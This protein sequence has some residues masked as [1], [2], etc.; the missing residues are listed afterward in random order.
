MNV[1]WK[2]TFGVMIV[3]ATVA[4][5]QSAIETGL[6]LSFDKNG[7][8]AIGKIAS[9]DIERQ[10][11]VWEIGTLSLEVTQQL[12]GEPL[13]TRFEIRFGWTDPNSSANAM[14]RA[15]MPPPYGFDRVR[16]VLGMNVLVIF[17][18]RKPTTVPPLAVLN[19]DSGEDTWV[20]LIKQAIG[21]SSLKGSDRV[22]TLL[23]GLDSS[24]E[25]IRVVSMHQ[26]RENAECQNGSGC[27]DNIVNLL[28]GRAKAGTLQERSKA[29]SW[30]D[31]DMYNATAGPTST[32][33]K[34]AAITL[35][36]VADSDPSIR[37]QAIE[38]LDQMIS[39]DRKWR[40][41]LAHLAIP[42]RGA[43]I[44]VLRQA[45]QKGG[46]AERVSSALGVER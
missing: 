6:Y 32:N 33:N 40:P 1:R 11:P 39:P 9:I 38:N 42:N 43:V 30:L 28:S 16:P 31:Y 12:R 22:D 27:A 29:I 14:S 13:P 20:P 3:M 10:S 23:R 19:L 45:R 41:D 18:R 21:F 36:L 46:E 15:K 5:G 2:R 25:F 37:G 17:D 34:I 7:P 4:R 26:L 24:Q 44:E 35:S 8:I